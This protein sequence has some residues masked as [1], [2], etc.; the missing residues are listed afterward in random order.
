MSRIA[1]KT[2]RA[3]R[4][5][6]RAEQA[7]ETRARILD[8]TLRVIASGIASLSIPAVARE[9]GVSIPTVY[10][11]FRTKA[12]LVA[13]VYPHAVGQATATAT[14][15][16]PESVA[17]FRELIRTFFARLDE[18]DDSARSAMASPAAEEVRRVSMPDRLARSRRFIAAVA[19]TAS[20]ADRERITRL[21]SVLTNSTAMGFWRDYFGSTADRAAD[22]IVWALR[23]AIAAASHGHDR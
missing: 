14:S 10:R 15:A 20:E 5:Q 16:A 18:L 17:E 12:D 7:E 6:L 2:G 9:A 1:N 13:A 19:P 11:N 3:Y 23:A 22:D 21:M 8:A 4:S